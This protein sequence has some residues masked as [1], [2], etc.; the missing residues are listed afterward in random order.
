MCQTYF[1][2]HF[3]V[4]HQIQYLLKF[5]TS[6]N[7]DYIAV[8]IVDKRKLALVKNPIAQLRKYVRKKKELA[9]FQQVSPEEVFTSIYETNKWGDGNTRSGKGSTLAYTQQLRN[10]LPTL[11]K[12]LETDTLLDIPCGDFHWM[13]EVSL[14]IAHYIGA[15]IVKPMIA[16]NQRLYSDAQRQF[17]ALDLLTDQLPPADTIFCR[18]CLVHLSFADINRAVAN[19]KS[20]KATFLITTNFPEINRN[21]D[22]V[23]GKHRVLN[24]CA[25][26]FHW[27]TP[28]KCIVEHEGDARRG[29]K[30]MAV[31]RITDLP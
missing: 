6:L 4:W 28:V 16:E 13:R 23:T 27:P 20:T 25:A 18:E 30:E 5:L 9:Y 12:A 31:W 19:I 2:P 29:R 21:K 1:I 8:Q 15:D 10:E 3:N 17:L 11:L 14:P 24:F 22:I 26:P 7:K